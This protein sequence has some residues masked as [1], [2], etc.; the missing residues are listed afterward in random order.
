MRWKKE[1]YIHNSLATWVYTQDILN[2]PVNEAQTPCISK[3]TIQPHKDESNKEIDGFY[4]IVTLLKEEDIQDFKTKVIRSGFK[5]DGKI[6]N[7]QSDG[8]MDVRL[9]FGC[10][11]TF[12]GATFEIV[13][14]LDKALK[15]IR[16][17]ICKDLGRPVFSSFQSTKAIEAEPLPMLLHYVESDLDL[18]KDR[19]K[20]MRSVSLEI[21][22]ALQA[23]MQ[24]LL[25]RPLREEKQD[26]NEID[27]LFGKL[28]S[29]CMKFMKIEG[30][31]PD[32]DDL[33]L[34]ILTVNPKWRYASIKNGSLDEEENCKD[35]D[36]DIEKCKFMHAA[37]GSKQEVTDRQYS[38]L[39][40]KSLDEQPIHDIKGDFHSFDMLLSFAD[41]QWELRNT[42][43]ALEVKGNTEKR[44]E[45]QRGLPAPHTVNPSAFS[46]EDEYKRA[47]VFHMQPRSPV[48]APT[49]SSSHG[50]H[51]QEYKQPE[52]KQDIRQIQA[53]A[54]Q[55]LANKST[56]LQ[57]KIA[58]YILNE[59]EYSLK[60][61]SSSSSSSA[62]YYA[63]LFSIRTAIPKN[64]ENALAK[65]EFDVAIAALDPQYTTDEERVSLIKASGVLQNLIREIWKKEK[66]DNNPVTTWVYTQDISN[67]RAKGAQKPCIA[68]IV[69]QPHKDAS[70]NH[71]V[72]GFY[73]I[74]TF[75]NEQ[76]ILTFKNALKD[77]GYNNEKEIE[78]H[79]TDGAMDVRLKFPWSGSYF[80]IALEIMV[81]LDEAVK[82]IRKE[83]CKDLGRP[84][85]SSFHT[86]EAIEDEPFEKLFDYIQSDLNEW[87]GKTYCSGGFRDALRSCMQ[88]LSLRLLG[89]EKPDYNETN[90][91]FGWLYMA[92]T[93]FMELDGSELVIHD[94]CL[95][96]LLV[97]PQWLYKAI[98]K[99]SPNEKENRETLDRTVEKLRFKHAQ[100][101]SR[102]EMTD[103]MF[104][105]ACGKTIT[106]KPIP[107]ITGAFTMLVSLADAQWEL[108]NTLKIKAQ[109]ENTAQVP[110]KTEGTRS[111]QPEQ[112]E[113]IQQIRARASQLLADKDNPATPLQI[114]IANY[115]LKENEYSIKHGTAG[116]SA[117]YP[118]MLFNGAMISKNQGNAL[119]KQ[120]LD[121]AYAALDPKYTT[122]E[123][124]ASF[125]K[126]SGVLQNLI[127]GI[128]LTAPDVSIFE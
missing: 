107:N 63:M 88:Q 59:N 9:K 60:H 11:A 73:M 8:E 18:N 106:E 79:P 7:H 14:S 127:S 93:N 62:V 2:L 110:K 120:E 31:T 102:Q 90:V 108:R 123:E 80:S 114:K 112:K 55:I 98:E 121:I 57:K 64:Q 128:L 95:D 33:C 84:V 86:T 119:A 81:P 61:G 16:E 65:Q 122:D 53:R 124:R 70:S 89:E 46:S 19:L 85:L 54:S 76:A 69:I 126:D 125:I 75:L 17:D 28:Y 41:E 23:C 97:R 116:S 39:C 58:N 92:A 15:E 38:N 13:V 5:M 78:K 74:V 35:L 67:L 68:K 26:A 29:L 40:G 34:N 109:A 113:E 44:E 105:N 101:G 72:D 52:Q 3:I 27:H 104:A 51:S 48:D 118:A 49:F 22:W 32:I 77:W 94:L 4:M 6:E 24:Q 66:L 87:K 37:R 1:A 10:W 36:R 25:S 117:A 83:I 82:E 96:I 12:F 30:A 103:R 20:Q 50:K 91:F 99:G 42:L 115:I 43:N 111:A 71:G 21:K 47:T 56:P 45:V 100:Q